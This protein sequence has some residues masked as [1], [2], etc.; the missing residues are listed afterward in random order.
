MNWSAIQNLLGKAKSD[1]LFLL[2]CATVPA[3]TSTAQGINEIIGA[4]GLENLPTGPGRHAFTAALISVLD[5]WTFRQ[6]FSAVMLHSEVLA[7]IKPDRPENGRST[8]EQTVEKGRTPIYLLTSGHPKF[9]SIELAR[10]RGYDDPSRA[11]A[12]FSRPAPLPS[13]NPAPMFSKLDVSNSG[14]LSFPHLGWV[15]SLRISLEFQDNGYSVLHQVLSA[16]LTIFC[17][18]H[19]IQ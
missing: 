4:C 14:G 15:M 16:M 17:C 19:I 18:R 10:R 2:D 1:V 9:P 11:S 7:V 13:T 12:N 8:D 3:E 6:S 5:D